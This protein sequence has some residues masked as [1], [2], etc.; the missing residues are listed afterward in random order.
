MQ[1]IQ[2]VYRYF[3]VQLATIK[4]VFLEPIIILD[5]LKIISLKLTPMLSNNL[6]EILLVIGQLGIIITEFFVECAYLLDL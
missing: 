2:V 3:I 4:L 1:Q 5:L 6:F